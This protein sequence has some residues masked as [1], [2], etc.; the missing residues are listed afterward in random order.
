MERKFELTC[1]HTVWSIVGRP[2]S[3]CRRPT[4]AAPIQISGKWLF[5]NF[6]PPGKRPKTVLELQVRY[7]HLANQVL[8]KGKLTPTAMKQDTRVDTSCSEQRMGK[9]WLRTGSGSGSRVACEQT[10]YRL[11]V[12]G[13]VPPRGDVFR[14]EEHQNPSKTA[15]KMVILL[16]FS[17][18][19]YIPQ[20]TEG[21]GRR[22]VRQ[23]GYGLRLLIFKMANNKVDLGQIR[24]EEIVYSRFIKIPLG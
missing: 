20:R 17:Y 5:E 14:T 3:L 9:S 1:T 23:R 16:H 13:K 4:S 22:A 18:T 15:E 8:W 21:F 10:V 2:F 6:T 7:F 11:S 19:F 12:W 24:S